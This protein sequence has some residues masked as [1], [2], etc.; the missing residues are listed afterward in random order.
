MVVK[1]MINIEVLKTPKGL[2]IDFINLTNKTLP[3][4]LNIEFIMLQLEDPTFT[5]SKKTIRDL[6][7]L[8][9]KFLTNHY[10]LKP[11]ELTELND[12]FNQPVEVLLKY[13][14]EDIII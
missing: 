1:S 6:I 4:Y 5:N 9:Y 12:W 10:D 3:Q 2:R 7:P 13:L 8:H 11:Q 14:D